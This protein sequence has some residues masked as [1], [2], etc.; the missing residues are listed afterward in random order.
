MKQKKIKE[1][2]ELL[3][4]TIQM[5]FDLRNSLVQRKNLAE[6]IETITEKIESMSA[7]IEE[8]RKILYQH[9]SIFFLE[10]TTG[11]QFQLPPAAELATI[12]NLAEMFGIDL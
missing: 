1:I 12:P 9:L 8:D 3:K 11:T 2:T 7:E 10:K 4:K 6:K 5:E